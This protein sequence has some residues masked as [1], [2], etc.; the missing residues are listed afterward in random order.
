MPIQATHG[1]TEG[2]RFDDPQCSCPLRQRLHD[3][4]RAD[5]HFV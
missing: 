5:K 4:R 2:D 3:E 1:I